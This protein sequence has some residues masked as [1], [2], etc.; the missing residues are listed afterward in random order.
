MAK[1]FFDPGGVAAIVW[2]LRKT[3]SLVS[4]DLHEPTGIRDPM[5]SGDLPLSTLI[6]RYPIFNIQMI[7]DPGDRT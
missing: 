5:G 4:W 7:E 1:T 3:L 2:A 6:D